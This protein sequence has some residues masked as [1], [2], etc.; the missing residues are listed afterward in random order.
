MNTIALR[1]RRRCC[2]CRRWIEPGETA[3]WSPLT[4]AVCADCVRQT[5]GDW[6]KVGKA[7]KA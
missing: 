4:R 3:V 2:A 6:A 5:T 7:A 1:G